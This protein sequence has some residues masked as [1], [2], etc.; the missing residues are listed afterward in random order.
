MLRGPNH[1]YGRAIGGNAKSNNK[2]KPENSLGIVGLEAHEFA[3]RHFGGVFR[4]L[5]YTT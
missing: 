2:Y 3:F 5:R 1:G 4:R